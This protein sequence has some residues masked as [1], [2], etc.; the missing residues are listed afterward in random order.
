MLD[1]FCTSNIQR[2][3]LCSR[4][5]VTYSFNIVLRLATCEPIR[6]KL[7]IVLNTTKLCR[8]LPVWITPIF[9][10]DHS[11]TEKL[12]GYLCSH[13]VVKHE[14]ALMHVTV[15]YLREMTVKKSCKHSKYGLFVY[16]LVL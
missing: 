3:E 12:V 9:T 10:Q 6:S 1:L 15:D 7:G 2:G 16:L 13:A 4:D 14:A 8:L 5:F 11:L